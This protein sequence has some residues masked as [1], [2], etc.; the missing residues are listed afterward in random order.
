M[1]STTLFWLF[2]IPP[3]VSCVVRVASAAISFEEFVGSMSCEFESID[4]GGFAGELRVHLSF[5][6]NQMN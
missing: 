4:A 1:S 2:D 3:S 5:V 6:V